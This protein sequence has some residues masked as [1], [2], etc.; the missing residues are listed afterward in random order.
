MIEAIV[1]AGGLG[2]RL[3]PIVQ[4]MPKVMATV[5]GKPFLE[6]VLANLARK[7]V[8]RVVLSVGFMADTIIGHFGNTFAGMEL[9][10]AIEETP[11]GTGGA[12][13][14]AMSKCEHDHVFIFNGDTFLDLELDVVERQWQF[15][16]VPL[17]IGRMVPDTARYGRL[18]IENERVT[19]YTEKGL[20][21]PGLINAGCYVFHRGQ[22]NS[23]P[24]NTA[25]S[26]EQDYFAK[27]LHCTS[28]GIFV[29]SGQF[30]DIGIPEDYARSQAELAWA[31]Q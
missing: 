15:D 26:I 29:T 28:I 31:C 21:G 1:L 30:I 8:N 2:T 10:Y 6:I 27:T 24:V 18:L 19:G 14:L 22:L 13:R 5:A 4:D 23:Y 3:R 11:L 16:Q 9:A 7:R 20:I 17:I 25:F 12:I